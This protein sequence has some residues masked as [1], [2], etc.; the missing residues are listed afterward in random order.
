MRR[1]SYPV[2]GAIAQQS[3]KPHSGPWRAAGQSRHP[4]HPLTNH[5]TR[6]SHNGQLR[7]PHQRRPTVPASG[8]NTSPI[9]STSPS[10][11]IFPHSTRLAKDPDAGCGRQIQGHIPAPAPSC[12]PKAGTATL[13]NSTGALARPPQRTERAHLSD[14]PDQKLNHVVAAVPT[15]SISTRARLRPPT[16]PAG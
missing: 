13:M 16:A 4:P 2:D 9:S 3:T 8:H 10:R 15:H 11:T 5:S 7:T 6:G 12:T 14:R 1:C